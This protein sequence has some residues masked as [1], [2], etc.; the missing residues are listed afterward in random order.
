MLRNAIARSYDSSVFSFL[1]NLQLFSI[2][3]SL[4]YIPTKSVGGFT[5]LYIVSSIYYL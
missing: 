4:I 1:R 3:A 2:V 5:F